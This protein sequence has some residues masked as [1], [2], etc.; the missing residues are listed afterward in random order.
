MGLW[1]GAAGRSSDPAWRLSEVSSSLLGLEAQ[2]P[3]KHIS[4]TEE[5]EEEEEGEHKEAKTRRP[6]RAN[7]RG[8]ALA[9]IAS[10]PLASRPQG[11]LW[12]A[13]GAVFSHVN[14]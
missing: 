11:G 8:I 12:A 10:F 9:A 2:L 7:E 1:A 5:A 6:S 14:I 4:I 3:Q 13:D